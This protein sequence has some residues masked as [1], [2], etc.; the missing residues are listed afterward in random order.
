MPHSIDNIR[1][2][3]ADHIQAGRRLIA[4]CLLKPLAPILF[5]KEL[6]LPAVVLFER[7]EDQSLVTGDYLR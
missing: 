2:R 7:A 3:H 1:T 4:Y 6:R 5:G